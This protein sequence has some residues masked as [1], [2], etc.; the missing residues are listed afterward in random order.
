LIPVARTAVIWAVGAMQNGP[1]LIYS[2]DDPEAVARAQARFGPERTGKIVEDAMAEIA[3]RLH[4]A[5]VRK[6]IVAGGETS[7]AFVE[8]L[9]IRSL[10]IGP[11]IEPGVPWTF[12]PEPEALC[13]AFKSGSGP[14]RSSKR[15]WGCSPHESGH[16]G[17]PTVCDL[18]P[19]ERINDRNGVSSSELIQAHSSYTP[20]VKKQCLIN[21][22]INS[23]P[24][25]SDLDKPQ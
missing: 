14:R 23:I 3:R 9:G 22:S 18:R 8:A 6:W 25:D 1:V 13:L 20:T 7:G 4:A 17:L 2:A 16:G 19:A 15:P 11:E 5:G 10:W 24:L 12:S 21:L